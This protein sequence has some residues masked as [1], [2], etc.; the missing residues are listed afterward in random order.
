MNN[1]EN[2]NT[3]FLA[4]AYG[5]DDEK[6]T[7]SF[8]AKWAADYDQ[9]MIDQLGYLSPTLIAG[10]MIQHQDN[11]NSKILDIGCGTGLTAAGLAEHGFKDLY[12]ID[13]SAEMVNV[14]ASRGIYSS[15]KVG[16]VNLPLDYDDHYFDGVISSGTFTH[17]H[18]GPEP[19][20]E[21]SRI[22]KP[23]GILACTVHGA[24]WEERGFKQKFEKL[25]SAKI[26]EKLSLTMDQYF[27]NGEPE[28]WFCIYRKVR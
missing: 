5:L 16:D 22:L 14:A 26:L 7:L 15:L 11:L 2:Q 24:L 3:K 20:T 10:K 21:I 23:G 12:G 18:V 4:E 17:G 19:L 28:G 1:A 25:V 6:S 8:Y 9:Q 27:N 13:L